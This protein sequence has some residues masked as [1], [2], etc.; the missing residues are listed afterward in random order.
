MNDVPT[1]DANRYSDRA[2]VP[3]YRTSVDTSESRN[4]EKVANSDFAIL[5]AGLVLHRALT[6]S[7]SGPTSPQVTRS[8]GWSVETEAFPPS[9]IRRTASWR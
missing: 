5:F 3:L 8:G 7:Q 1:F 9:T 6:S 2:S 4:L